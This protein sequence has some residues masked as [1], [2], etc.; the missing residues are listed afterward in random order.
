[1]TYGVPY[2]GSKN[3]CAQWVIDHLP[4]GDRLVDLFAGGCAITHC[5]LLT[6][7]WPRMLANDIDS[8]P[9]LFYCAAHGRY[10]NENRWISREDFFKLKDTDPYVRWCWS[11]GFDGAS[12]LYGKDIE[13]Y[14]Q[15][16]NEM[17]T[18]P[19]PRERYDAYRR[20]MKM[21]EAAPEHVRGDKNQ[22]LIE[23][24]RLERLERLE[25]S[26]LDYRDVQIKPGDVIYCDPPYR[27]TGAHYVKGF[28]FE[29]F[30]SWAESQTVPV[31]ISEYDMPGD[32]FE[33]IAER[34]RHDH[35]SATNK[36]RKVTERLF[37]PKTAQNSINLTNDKR[38]AI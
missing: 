11:F 32:R 33:C 1:M 23:L 14:K 18:A 29:A 9:Q 21:L 16:V 36:H 38:Q 5:A 19:T 24:E 25:V 10:R 8:G 35:L 26:R 30:Y 37:V 28:D 34:E 7:K 4:P 17:L 2:I 27:G 20:Y 3:A 6:E 15:A 31:I 22:R 12:Y 13:P